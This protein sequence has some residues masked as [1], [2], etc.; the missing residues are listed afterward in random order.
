M[1][2]NSRRARWTSKYIKDNINTQLIGEVIC[3][4]AL[5]LQRTA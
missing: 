2:L 3:Q 4:D 1:D 5:I